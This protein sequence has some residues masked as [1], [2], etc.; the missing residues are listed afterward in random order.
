MRVLRCTASTVAH[1]AVICGKVFRQSPSCGL[2]FGFGVTGSQLP[3]LHSAPQGL[4]A[5]RRSDLFRV[6]PAL[7]L[8][9]AAACA[10]H[11]SLKPIR[12]RIRRTGLSTRRRFAQGR[13]I[14]GP[15]KGPWLHYGVC[16]KSGAL[17]RS[18]PVA[19]PAPVMMHDIAI[20]ANFTLFY[21]YNN[22]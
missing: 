18:F 21:D 11:S 19:I 10:R 22:R 8:R 16:D 13:Y 3:D 7:S 1:S 20:T 2:E 6:M 12:M 17:V 14:N 5:D 9:S 15:R 4:P